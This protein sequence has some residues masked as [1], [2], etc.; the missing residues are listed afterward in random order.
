MSL[1]K[2][3]VRF[4]LQR[5][6]EWDY[7]KT[8]LTPKGRQQVATSA[9]RNLKGV[10]FITPAYSSPLPRAVETLELSASVATDSTLAKALMDPFTTEEHI[11]IN[12]YFGYT[13]AQEQLQGQALIRFDEFLNA[14]AEEPSR[15]VTLHHVLGWWQPMASAIRIALQC[16]MKHLAEH[17]ASQHPTKEA[18]NVLVSTH[19]TAHFASPNPETM[20]GIIEPGRI[21]QYTWQLHNQRV[22][23]LGTARLLPLS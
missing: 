2:Q 5:H 16:T 7:Q 19:A 12:E 15:G 13:F 11:F 20:P 4:Y 14:I 8:C 23:E 1:Q 9:K 3:I 18:I 17:L 10:A 21:V 22:L 6:G